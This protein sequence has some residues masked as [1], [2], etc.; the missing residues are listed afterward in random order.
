M[1]RSGYGIFDVH[2]TVSIYVT[3]YAL[4]LLALPSFALL[5][6]LAVVGKGVLVVSKDSLSELFTW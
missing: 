6:K 4:Y 2:R 1:K 5:S 3:T